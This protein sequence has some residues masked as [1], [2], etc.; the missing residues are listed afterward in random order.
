[1]D[2]A[3]KSLGVVSQ[4]CKTFEAETGIAFT[5]SFSNYLSFSND[6]GKMTAVD[7]KVFNKEQGWRVKLYNKQ[8]FHTTLSGRTSVPRLNL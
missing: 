7:E 4:V 8:L 1:M 2:R 5:K 6:L 3:T